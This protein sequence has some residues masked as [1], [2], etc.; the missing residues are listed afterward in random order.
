[1][2]VLFYGPYVPAIS[3]DRD[4]ATEEMRQAVLTTVRSLHRTW[5]VANHHL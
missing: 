3:T 2:P 5:L 1:M 4:A